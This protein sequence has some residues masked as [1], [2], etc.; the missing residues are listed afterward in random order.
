MDRKETGHRY[1]VNPVTGPV[2]RRGSPIYNYIK[3]KQK[4]MGGV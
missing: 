2:R 3:E 4:V 1:I